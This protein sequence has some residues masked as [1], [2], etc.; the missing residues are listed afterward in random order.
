MIFGT[1]TFASDY[2]TMIEQE[3]HAHETQH[4]S[5]ELAGGIAAL[6]IGLY[7]YYFDDRGVALRAV[8]AAAQTIGVLQIGESIYNANKPSIPLTT[9]EQLQQL[10]NKQGST[11]DL[12]EAL[13]RAYRQDR[14]ASSKKLA[15]ASAILAVLYSINGQ[16]EKARNATIA[17]VYRFLAFNAALVSGANFYKSYGE[18]DTKVAILVPRVPNENPGVLLSWELAL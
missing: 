16:H 9:E 12:R 17:N 3:Q 8:Y 6:S 2:Q 10:E 18:L 5:E 4:F 14:L 15:Y 1:S 13:G 7:G 11:A